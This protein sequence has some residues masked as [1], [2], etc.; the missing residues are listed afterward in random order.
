MVTVY[1][2]R[3]IPYEAFFLSNMDFYAHLHEKIELLY[4]YE[5][6]VI[7]NINGVEKELKPGEMSIVFPDIVH[8]YHTENYS[9]SLTIIFA[10]E[11]VREYRQLLNSK[12]PMFP[13]LSA[14]QIH[15]EII[16]AFR[17]ISQNRNWQE[18]ERILHGYLLIIMGYIFN[19]LDLIP[20]EKRNEF[21]PSLLNY[22]AVHFN[23]RLTLDII[24]LKLGVSKYQISRYFSHKIGCNFNT[25]LNSL[26]IQ[27]VGH[28]LLT[29]D[30]PITDIS[31]Q[32]GFES[33][34][35]FYRT[36][37]QQYHMTPSEFKKRSKSSAK[38]HKK[39]PNPAIT[40][41]PN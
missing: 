20:I 21:L 27:H 3:D 22:L 12:I 16:N 40:G 11:L 18:D 7:V 2:K 4:L 34:S 28:L 36:F 35:S 23:E 8:S 31:Y 5:G 6:S 24:A 19:S 32:S 29:T 15:P 1:E 38:A 14:N 26:R 25:Y 17:V 39:S 30:I 33:L 41:L 10:P 9:Y 13:Y 37:Q